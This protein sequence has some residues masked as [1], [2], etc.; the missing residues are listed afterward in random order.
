MK[1]FIAAVTMT[2]RILGFV[3]APAIGQRVLNRCIDCEVDPVLYGRRRDMMADVLREAGFE[4]YLPPGAFY[5]FPKAPIE[6]DVEFVRILQGERVLAVPGVGFGMAG[7]IRL[8]FC[9]PERTITESLPSFK[10]AM[11]AARR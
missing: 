6:D 10:R 1:E 9:V 5:F 8:A 7:F 4:F 2:N 11:A 3:N